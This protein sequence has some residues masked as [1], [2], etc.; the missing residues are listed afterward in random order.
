MLKGIPMAESFEVIVLQYLEQ[1]GNNVVWNNGY[2][3]NFKKS[4]WFKSTIENTAKDENKKSL[5]KFVKLVNDVFSDYKL[6][7]QQKQ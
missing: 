2:Y 3:I 5:E 4:T 1:Q 6:K 7:R